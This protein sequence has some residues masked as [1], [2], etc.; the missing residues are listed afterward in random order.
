MS[1]GVVRQSAD[2]T[3]IL[4]RALAPEAPRGAVVLLH[5][6]GEHSGRYQHVLEYLNASGYAAHT[7]DLR[8]HGGSE[9]KRGHIASYEVA[10]EDIQA[11]LDEVRQRYPDLPVFLYGHSFGGNLALTFAITRSPPLD[12]LIATSPGLAPGT[13]VPPL[14]RALGKLLYRLAPSFT[15]PNGLP[16]DGLSRDPAVAAAV[17]ADP[18]YHTRVSARLGLDILASG[19]RIRAFRGPLPFP[20]LIMTGTED[21]VTDPGAPLELARH[22]ESEVTTKTWD[23]FYHEL[24]NEPQWR[25]VLGFC[26]A[27]MGRHGRTGGGQK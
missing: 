27:W 21:R 14:K 18:L 3:R 6:L 4:R 13:P 9:G 12:G 16:L 7:F 2:G 24:H 20:V 5:G 8:G 15:L 17:K 22:L 26:V 10:M 11:Q 19:E 1:E 23:G 25:D